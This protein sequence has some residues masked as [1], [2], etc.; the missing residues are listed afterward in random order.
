[1]SE[2]PYV[3][4]S[5]RLKEPRIA[6]TWRFSPRCGWKQY[7]INTVNSQLNNNTTSRHTRVVETT[8][9]HRSSHVFVKLRNRGATGG[10]PYLGHIS[11]RPV[12]RIP[13]S[14]PSCTQERC[15]ARAP[16][17][18]RPYHGPGEDS[19]CSVHPSGPLAPHTSSSSHA[20]YL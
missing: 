4:E 2:L 11:M 8:G 3:L 15:A 10:H 5:I 6:T 19:T 1:M 13:S 17:S 12:Q 9:R 20:L 7:D 14:G 18:G 16:A